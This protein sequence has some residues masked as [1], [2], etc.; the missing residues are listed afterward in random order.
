MEGRATKPSQ[1]A[2]VWTELKTAWHGKDGL[3]VTSKGPYMGPMQMSFPSQEK[4]FAGRKWH[5]PE[6]IMKT[7]G[8]DP[9]RTPQE[10]AESFTKKRR[11]LNRPVQ[12]TTE[13]LNLPR[14]SSTVSRPTKHAMART[15]R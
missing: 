3:L 11:T 9:P 5:G 8:G 4:I 2:G 14:H 7:L 10:K 15:L 6:V 12:M 13:A 1:G